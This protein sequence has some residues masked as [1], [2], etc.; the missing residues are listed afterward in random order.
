MLHGLNRCYGSLRN[1]KRRY[2]L[3]KAVRPEVTSG[4]DTMRARVGGR[5]PRHQIA[6]GVNEWT[7]GVAYRLER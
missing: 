4:S 5:P 1:P 2:D 7:I 3:K 6:E